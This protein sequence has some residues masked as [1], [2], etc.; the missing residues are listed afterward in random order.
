MGIWRC[1]KHC[2]LVFYLSISLPSHNYAYIFLNWHAFHRYHVL[3]HFSSKKSVSIH[4]WELSILTILTIL[5]TNEIYKRIILIPCVH[6]SITVAALIH[7]YIKSLELFTL[8]MKHN[9]TDIISYKLKI[10]H[11]CMYLHTY[12]HAHIIN[13]HTHTPPD[14]KCTRSL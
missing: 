9:I 10:K 6:V 14:T 4:R 8:Y 3:K 13:L 1:Q 11:Y 7:K 12:M 2:E 5:P